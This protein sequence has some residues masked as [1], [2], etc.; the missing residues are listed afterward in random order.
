MRRRGKAAL[1]QQTFPLTLAHGLR[2]AFDDVV[3]AMLPGH[4]AALMRQLSAD[5]DERMCHRDSA[6]AKP[7]EKR[8]PIAPQE[9]ERGNHSPSLQNRAI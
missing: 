4:L 8:G 7:K 9:D 2:S 5:G 6:T 3:S 1:D